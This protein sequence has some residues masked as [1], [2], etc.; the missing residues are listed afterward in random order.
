MINL[1]VQIQGK[2]KS[3]PIFINNSD[4][5]TLKES[6]LDQIEHKNYIV[7][8]NQTV[9]KLYSKVLDFPKD[10]IFVL[11]DGEREKNYK[12]YIKILNFALQKKLKRED[13]IIAIG[14]GVVGD[15][16]GFAAATFMRGINFIQVPTTLL[17]AVDSSVGGKVAINSDYG[18]NLIGAFYQPKTVFINVN[19]L[20]TLDEKQFKSGLG[21]VLKYGFIEKSCISDVEPHL[22]NFLIENKDKI[23]AKEL[24][25]LKELIKLCLQLK[26]EVVQ[27]DEKEGGLRKILN[28]GHTY[29][30]V[31]ENLTGYKKYTHGECVIEG[32]R[33]ALALATKLNLVDKE[34]KFLSEDLIE[35][36]DYKPLKSFDINKTIYVMT[37]D[38]KATDEYITFI[39]PSQYAQVFEYKISK[40]ELKKLITS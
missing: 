37:T 4:L 6:I 21:E 35:K 9:H 22:I 27:K 34:Y 36:F 38:K 30:H 33:F 23:L 29:G 19:F 31:V 17:S 18:K 15:I 24:L 39:L 14:G 11:K 13:A 7:V 1:M 2:E 20:K 40:E 5:S 16:A 26:I 25:T 10:K 3:Y 12:N 8:I 28:Y 32:I